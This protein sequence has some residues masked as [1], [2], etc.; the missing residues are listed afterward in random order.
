MSNHFGTLYIKGLKAFKHPSDQFI[1][2]QHFSLLSSKGV[3]TLISI[4][5][6]WLGKQHLQPR[7]ASRCM[8][9]S[10]PIE[11][12]IPL[13]S[14]SNVCLNE[15]YS[16]FASLQ[17]GLKTSIRH[18]MQTSSIRLQRNSFLFSMRLQDVFKTFWEIVMI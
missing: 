8:F 10:F 3:T 9:L 14:I 7:K 6:F 5:S 13:I 4:N 18:I 15:Q 11:A 1:V 12:A 17:D 16:T 2:L